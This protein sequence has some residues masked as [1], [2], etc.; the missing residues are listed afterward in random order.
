VDVRGTGVWP[1]QLPELTSAQRN[2]RD[3]FMARWLEVLPQRYG[4]IERFNHG[5]PLASAR[6][7]RTLEIGAGLGEHYR[8]EKPDGEYYAVELREE[9]VEALRTKHPGITAL[10][11]DCQARLPFNDGFFDRILAIHV[12]EHLND[13]PRALNE[14]ARLLAPSGTFVTVIP[15]E[16]GL[17]YTLAR[18]VSAQRVFER[19]FGMPYEWLIRSE[20]LNVPWEIESEL[21]KRFRI[22]DTRYFPFRVPSVSLNLV[23]GLTMEQLRP[24][25]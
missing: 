20:H 3:R 4:V 17:A 19:E 21:R 22:T 15:C 13:L 8:Y 7:G 25:A 18:R 12:L 10:V 2:L 16:G 9:L 11:G 5:Y 1:K 23:V 6:I 24:T 14:V